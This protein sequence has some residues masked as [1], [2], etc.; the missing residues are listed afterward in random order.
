MSIPLYEITG[1]YAQI[2]DRFYQAESESELAGIADLLAQVEDSLADKLDNCARVYRAILAEAEIFD[3]EAKRLAGKADALENRAARLKD[4]IGICLGVGNAMK[5][6]LFNFTWRTSSAVEIDSLESLP[7]KYLRKKTIVEPNK[8]AIKDELQDE[9][10]TIPGA[11]LV[12]RM[13]LQIK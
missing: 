9:T 4:Y 12:K 2:L 3:E 13:N 11:R 1:R 5:S 8:E 7:E 6:K 10:L